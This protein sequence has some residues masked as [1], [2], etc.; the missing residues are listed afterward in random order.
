MFPDMGVF[1]GSFGFIGKGASQ[2]E[3][4]AYYE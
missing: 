4:D 3:R 1:M 2:L